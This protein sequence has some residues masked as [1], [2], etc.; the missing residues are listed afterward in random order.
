MTTCTHTVSIQN[1]KAT[2]IGGDSS[3]YLFFSF[4]L[5]P[6]DRFWDISRHLDSDKNKFWWGLGG[7]EV[8]VLGVLLYVGFF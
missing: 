2:W 5:T 7:G 3:L 8:V 1:L 6:N 4:R